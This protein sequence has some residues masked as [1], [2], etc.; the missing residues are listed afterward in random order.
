MKPSK[1]F[2]FPK[3]RPLPASK[4]FEVYETLH[5]AFGHQNWWP[6]ETP[7]EV[8]VGA[9][10]TQN[11]SWT[12][13]E[14]AIS[15]LK[16]A[17]RLTLLGLRD[18]PQDELAQ[19]IRPAG[20]FNM[21]AQRLKFFVHFLFKEYD[22][23]LE[24]MRNED[25]LLLREKILN[26]N[27]IGP[28]TA[29]SIL[30]YALN[31][32]FFVIDAYTKRIF[33]RHRIQFKSASPS[34]RRLLEMPYAAWQSLFMAHLPSSEPLFNDFH[35]Q[36]VHTAKHYCKASEIRCSSCPLNKYL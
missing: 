28:E 11:T 13:V 10:L 21:K 23:D 25:D 5:R 19:L 29:D 15:N 8:M 33:A 7:F 24:R 26:V 36:I 9:I 20:Y 27:G 16:K 17:K 6:G 14:K 2:L 4:L 12:N 22:G 35:A 3:S 30:L 18:I 1:P 32:P 34:P 31:K